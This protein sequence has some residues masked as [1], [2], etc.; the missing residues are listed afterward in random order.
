MTRDL[1]HQV[2]PHRFTDPDVQPQHHG[3]ICKRAWEHFVFTRWH[4]RTLHA[5]TTDRDFVQVF[6]IEISNVIEPLLRLP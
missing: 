6:S 5:R 1:F 4:H 3:S 2:Y